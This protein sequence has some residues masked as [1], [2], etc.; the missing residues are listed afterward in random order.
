MNKQLI[1]V[2]IKDLIICDNSKCDYK[3]LSETGNPNEDI[4]MYLNKP[5]PKCGEN[6]LTERDYK[7]NL[8]LLSVINWI[9]KWFSWLV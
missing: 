7:K 2:F 1:D 3:I 8:Y 9:N 5:C 6:L 4:S